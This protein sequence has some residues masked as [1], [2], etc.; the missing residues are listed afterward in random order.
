MTLHPDWEYVA[1]GVMGGV[2]SGQMRRETV[3]GRA[4]ARLIG[5]VSLDNNGG[6]IQMAFDVTGLDAS[7]WTGIELDVIGNGEVYDLRLRT[8][9]LTRPWQSYRTEFVAPRS[10]E[11]VKLPFA[12]FDAHRTDAPLALQRLRRVG[13]L[14]IGRV[15]DADVAVAGV[16]LY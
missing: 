1:D 13:V 8:Q 3:E 12:A 7:G 10:W 15:F 2:S 4:A 11:T 14:A 16:R 5:T 9:D 6:F